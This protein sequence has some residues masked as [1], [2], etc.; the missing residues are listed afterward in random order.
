MFQV[1]QC[2]IC[3]MQDFKSELACTDYTV[4]HETFTI[5]KCTH[6]QFLMTNP[7]PSNENLGQYY[8]SENYIS[9]SEKSKS[10]IDLIY[11]IS[12]LFTLR[13]KFNL[14]KENIE[15][16]SF[17]LL[18]YGCGAGDFLSEC[19][20]RKIS[21]SGVEPS[22]NARKIAQEKI[23]SNVHSDISELNQKFTAIT[24][25]HVLEH[26]PDL[27][28]KLCQLKEHLEENGTIFIAVP[29]HKSYDSQKYKSQ[30]AGYDVPRHLWHFSK[31]NVEQLLKKN[32]LK[33][34]K[35]VPMKLDSFYVSILSHKNIQG[36]PTIFGFINGLVT[37]LI[38]NVKASK[39]NNYSS[40]IYI[41][42]KK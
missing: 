22:D 21:V 19:R 18:D 24:L 31:E 27:K 28:E 3:G 38:S 2:P 26:I 34:K 4:S 35:I 42:S 33:L 17:T 37:G 12:R 11:R 7:R 39:S 16:R 15:Q 25:W 6:C 32:G 29:N 8:M 40:L 30:W 36:K 1:Q 41:A 9:H 23:T 10:I 5:V 13:W 14:V 20:K